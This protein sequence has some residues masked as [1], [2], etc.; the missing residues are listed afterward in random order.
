M[1][2]SSFK[3]AKSLEKTN[4]KIGIAKSKWNDK[5]VDMLVDS[6][7]LHLEQNNIKNIKV[8]EVP[9]TWE[10]V[11][12]TKVLLEKYDCDGVIS[13]GV[14]IRGET[15]HYDLISEN[16]VSGLMNLILNTSKPVTLGILATEDE[17]QAEERSN[18]NKLDKGK[19]FAQ[20]ILEVLNL[21][22]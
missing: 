18:P 22:I 16:V 6:A 12:A 19:E 17:V 8:I 7:V 3:F 21:N 15:T 1:S 2:N 13:I 5:Y 11:Y 10:L 9:G 14:I 4:F 20:T